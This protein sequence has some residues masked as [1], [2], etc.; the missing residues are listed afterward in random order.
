[1]NKKKTITISTFL[2][3]NYG[4]LLQ[5]YALQKYLRNKGLFKVQNLDF[6]T[7]EHVK[8]SKVFNLYGS[9]KSRMSQLFFINTI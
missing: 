8:D 3:K 5:G 2:Y 6:F 7:K 4:G 1:M 9:I